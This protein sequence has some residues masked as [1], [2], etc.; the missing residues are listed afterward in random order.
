MPGLERTGHLSPM[1]SLGHWME[2][3]VQLSAVGFMH[4]NYWRYYSGQSMAIN[5]I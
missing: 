1:I 4:H 2:V 3:S 5:Q